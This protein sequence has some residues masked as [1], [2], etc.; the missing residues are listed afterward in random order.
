MPGW[1]LH[2]SQDNTLKIHHF[3]HVCGSVLLAKNKGNDCILPIS[4]PRSLDV[5]H[6]D[7]LCCLASC[8]SQSGAQ[9]LSPHVA[10]GRRYF[11]RNCSFDRSQGSVLQACL[12]LALHSVAILSNCTCCIPEA[13]VSLAVVAAKFHV[14]SSRF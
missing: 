9:K 14:H 10:P 4:H 8:S 3:H 7:D 12:E 6:A 11:P 13:E 2:H 5:V 1:V